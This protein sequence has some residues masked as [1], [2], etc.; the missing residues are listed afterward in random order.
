MTV[1]DNLRK[2]CQ[3]AWAPMERMIEDAEEPVEIRNAAKDQG[4]DWTP[5][6]ALLKARIQDE[7]DGGDRVAKLVA[8]AD[9]ASEYAA[10]LN[11]VADK[12][13]TPPQLTEPVAD[14][15]SPPFGDGEAAEDAEQASA[16]SVTPDIADQP[17]HRAYSKQRG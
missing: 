17:V 5:V 10:I 16:A 8:K 12:N 1:A 9:T 11:F 14:C 2:V 7:R 13:K 4:L 6:K 3:A 15:A